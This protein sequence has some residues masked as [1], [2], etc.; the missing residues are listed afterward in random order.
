VTPLPLAQDEEP[1]PTTSDWTLLMATCR[2]VWSALMVETS[3]AK[4]VT[5]VE[6]R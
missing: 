2:R 1:S 3:V 6:R 5:L 4:V